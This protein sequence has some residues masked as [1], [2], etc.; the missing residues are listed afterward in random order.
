MRRSRAALLFALAMIASAACTFSL[1][2]VKTPDAQADASS[3]AADSPDNHAE[4]DADVAVSDADADADADA[5]HWCQT[6][7][8]GALFCKDFDETPDPGGWRSL[9]V[10][11]DARVAELAS[12]T[13]VTPPHAYRF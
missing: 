13:F 2:E 12:D 9:A 11:S 1:A 5:G 6:Y 7:G 3:D 10:S 4:T 8:G